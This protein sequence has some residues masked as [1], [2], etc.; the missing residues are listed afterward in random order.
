MRTLSVEDDVIDGLTLARLQDNVRSL[1]NDKIDRDE[2]A[3]T[4]RLMDSLLNVI[5]FYSD[6][7]SYATFMSEID[8]SLDDW[9]EHY[10]EAFVDNLGS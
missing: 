5:E 9:Q 4:V 1:L 3:Y 6:P 10:Y 2:L 7:T 8:D